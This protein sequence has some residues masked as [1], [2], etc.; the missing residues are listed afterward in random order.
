MLLVQTNKLFIAG[1][2]NVDGRTQVQITDQIRESRIKPQDSYTKF[3]K[4]IEN[5][6]ESPP[7]TVPPGVRQK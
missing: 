5:H 6:R 7:L 2:W 1:V 3:N 4:N